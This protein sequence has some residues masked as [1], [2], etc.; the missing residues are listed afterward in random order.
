MECLSVKL[1]RQNRRRPAAISPS[2]RTFRARTRA[3]RTV[4]FE[5]PKGF[6]PKGDLKPFKFRLTGKAHAR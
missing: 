1:E 2:W 5:K 4:A 3:G 6:G